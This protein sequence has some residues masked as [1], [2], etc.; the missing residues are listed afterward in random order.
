MKKLREFIKST[1]VGGLLVLLPMAIFAYVLLWVFNLIVSLINPLTRIV[2]ETSR[3]QGIVADIVAIGLLIWICFLVGMLV[4]TRL[5]R[6]AYAALEAGFLK[7]TPGYSMIKE[8]VTHFLGENKQSPFSSVALA[9]IFGNDTL[10]SVFVTDTHEDG[11]YTVFMP[12]GP[13]PTS[14]NIYH[15]KAENVFPVDVSVEDAM[16]SIISCGAGSSTLVNKFSETQRAQAS[17]EAA[18]EKP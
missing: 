8:T 3:V 1:L 15:L 18:S 13:N 6:W 12:T 14:G 4:R 17:G 16:R 11:S 10:V 2:M 9:R 5:G 7:K